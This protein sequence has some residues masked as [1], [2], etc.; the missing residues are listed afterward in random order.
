MAKESCK[1]ALKKLRLLCRKYRWNF[2]L[3]FRPKQII[4]I[5]S[6]NEDSN[7]TTFGLNERLANKRATLLASRLTQDSST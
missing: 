3:F 2:I 4:V 5:Q 7:P 1:N 6:E